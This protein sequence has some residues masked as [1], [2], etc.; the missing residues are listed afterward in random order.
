MWQVEDYNKGIIPSGFTYG[1]YKIEDIDK[2]GKYTADMDR[3]ILG[4]TDPLYR[5]SIQNDFKYKNF[6]LK[7]FINAVQGGSDHYLG[8]PA[9]GIPTPDNLSTWSFYKF[10]Y[11]T[12]ENPEH[13]V[14]VSRR[15]CLVASYVYRNC[16]FLT[17][18]HKIG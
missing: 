6:N 18:C 11:W 17:I 16:H 8:Q 2:D 3:K 9:A 14:L 10:D 7:V 5:F 15:M 12:P 13:W 1:T 4:Y